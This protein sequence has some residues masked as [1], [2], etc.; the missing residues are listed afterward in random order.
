MIASDLVLQQIAQTVQEVGRYSITV[1]ETSDI[2]NKEQ[3]CVSQACRWEA[4][5]AFEQQL[6]RITLYTI[7]LMEL[8]NMKDAKASVDARDLLTSV[9][10][11]YS[12][13]L[14]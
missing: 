10:D 5:K 14:V 2:S 6:V 12:S 1:D 9:C 7:A 13:L 4:V 8:I 3:V 11:L